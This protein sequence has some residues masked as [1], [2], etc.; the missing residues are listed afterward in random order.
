MLDPFDL[1]PPE[2]LLYPKYT[3][4]RGEP[5]KPQ[6]KVVDVSDLRDMFNEVKNCCLHDPQWTPDDVQ[7][8]V[9]WHGDRTTGSESSSLIIAKLKDGKWG[10]FTQEEDYTGHGC[11]CGSMSVKEDTLHKLITHLSEYEL[12]NFLG[13]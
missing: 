4:F 1:F 2:K 13:E 8:I 12:L 7:K 3:P 11:R 10:L 6:E 9:L 5:E